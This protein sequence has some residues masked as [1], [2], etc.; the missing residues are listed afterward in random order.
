MKTSRIVI[1]V[2]GIVMMSVIFSSC[3]VMFGGSKFQGSIVAKEHPNATIYVNGS[4]I[5]KGSAM[6]L[7]PRNRPLT[8]EL[9]EEG[10]A[11]KSQTFNNTFRGGNFALSFISWGLTGII[12]DLVAGASYKPDHKHNPAVEKLSDKNFSFIVDYSECTVASK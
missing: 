9:R 1:A 3:G 8:V 10:C 2:I 4:P 7:F 5:G 6:G 11:A 12:V